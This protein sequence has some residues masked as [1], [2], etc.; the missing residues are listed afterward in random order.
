M[1]KLK[2]IKNSIVNFIFHTPKKTLNDMEIEMIK[3]NGLIHF[4][5]AE[6][7][8][9]IIKEGAKGNLKKPMRKKERGFTWFYINDDS[10]FEERA[11]DIHSKGIRKNYDSYVVFKDIE[12]NQIKKL[13]I[14]RR[15]DCAII[16]PSDFSTTNMNKYLIQDRIKYLKHI[17]NYKNK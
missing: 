13:R 1:V 15:T 12:D 2:K 11:E 6:S 4:C 3:L 10:T 8:T 9:N 5:T 7:A 14:R 16:Y 17:S